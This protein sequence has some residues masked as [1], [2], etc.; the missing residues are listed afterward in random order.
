MRTIADHYLLRV[1]GVIAERPQ[2][3]FLRVALALRG[4]DLI[5]VEETYDLLSRQ[6]LALPP[7]FCSAA[8]TTKDIMPLTGTVDLELNSS[9]G[10]LSMPSLNTIREHWRRGT[11][12]AAV[13]S[14][15]SQTGCV[16]CPCIST[17]HC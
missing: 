14:P 15:L 12:V 11:H 10:S 8:C 13:I 17:L 6:V 3:M 16:Y 9:N 2:F 1:N 4:L 7:Q 5:A